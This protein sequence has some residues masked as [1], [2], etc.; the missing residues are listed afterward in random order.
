M[1]HDRDLDS[2]QP[3]ARDEVRR[4]QR[5]YVETWVAALR[6]DRPDLDADGAHVRAHACFGLLNATPH[7]D[8]PL[9]AVSRPVLGRMALA[10][11]A[12]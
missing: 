2:L 4:L 11:L 1:L 10:A 3:A 12:A 7:L 6:R 8:P 5:S 9:M